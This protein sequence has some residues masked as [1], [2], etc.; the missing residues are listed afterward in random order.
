M[1]N[2]RPVVATICLCGAIVVAAAARQVP[3]TEQPRADGLVPAS[4]VAADA[5]S[6]RNANYEIDARLDDE[7]KSIRGRETIRWRNITDQATS[8]L[9]F[10]LYWNAWRDSQSTWLRERRMAGLFRPPRADAWGSMDV[11]SLRLR[12]PSGEM[13]DVTADMRFI[14]PDDGNARDR[15][16]MTVPLGR[17]VGP[18]ESVEI[19]VEWTAK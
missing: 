13:R 3:P 1:S 2:L 6:P 11:S 10:H 4:Q 9:Q 14:A 5:R 15:T 8:E 17:S 16:V 7:A 12:E 19:E 18:N